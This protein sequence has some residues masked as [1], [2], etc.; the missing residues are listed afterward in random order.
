VIASTHR[1]GPVL[2]VGA[3][4]DSVVAGAGINDNATGVAALLELARAVRTRAPALAV[5]FA[6]WG[7]EEF[8]LIGS[9]AYVERADLSRV[10]GY[11][12]FDMLGSSGGSAGV[13]QGPF[14]ARF[15][16]YFERRGLPAQA[17]DLEGRSDHAPFQQA[18][19]PTGGLFAGTDRCY[20]AA[21]DRLGNV[22]MRLLGQLASAAA[23]GVASIAPM[24]PRSP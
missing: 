19:I 13:Y 4:R 20:H 23:Y 24:R 17:V 8:G 5:R 1:D 7:A 14:A 6:F 9:R 16:T 15:L 2:V 3:H 21:C 10:V 11:L 18:G 12:N 22:N